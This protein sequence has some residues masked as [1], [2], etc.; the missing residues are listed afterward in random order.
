MP[1]FSRVRST[2]LLASL[3]ELLLFLVCPVLMENI[4][5]LPLPCSL[6]TILLNIF[7]W[8]LLLQRGIGNFWV[9]W[10]IRIVC[11]TLRC[12]FDYFV[13]HLVTVYSYVGLDPR[14]HYLPSASLQAGNLF[15]NLLHQQAVV[16]VVLN[17]VQS[18]RAVSEYCCRKWVNALPVHNIRSREKRKTNTQLIK[19]GEINT[20][21]KHEAIATIYKGAIVPLL[22]YGATVWIEAMYFEHNRQ[23]YIRVQRLINIRIAKAFRTT[24]SEALCMLTGMTAILI[25]LEKETARHKIKQNSA[26]RDKEWDCD[27]GIKNWPHPAEVGAIHEVVG[28][29]ERSIQVYTDGANK[30]KESDQEQ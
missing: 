10:Y 2:R 21:I 13:S 9:F 11:G 3:L 30:N 28:N 24:S 12:L 6:L 25:K 18:N 4:V 26:H 15:S 29:E 23:K 27:V 16:V 7:V 8:P 17:R 5:W 1:S 22:T 19:S 14:E 20:G